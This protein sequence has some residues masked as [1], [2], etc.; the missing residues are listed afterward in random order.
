[1]R[2][3]KLVLILPVRFIVLL[4]IVFLSAFTVKAMGTT[5]ILDTY[6]RQGTWVSPS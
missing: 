1:M 6:M 5:P 3:A 2:P 4:R